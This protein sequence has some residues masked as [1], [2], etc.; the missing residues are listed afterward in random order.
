MIKIILFRDAGFGLR[1]WLREGVNHFRSINVVSNT[2]LFHI[3]M[4][5][6]KRQSVI[7]QFKHGALNHA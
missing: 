7:N 1:I 4:Y 3:Q 5:S 6:M 2:K